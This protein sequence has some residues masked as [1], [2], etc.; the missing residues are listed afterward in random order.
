MYPYLKLLFT[1]Y[2]ARKHP[3][4]TL[5]ESSTL[6]LRAGLTD[7][8]IFF[9]LNHA[10]YI[11]YMELARWDHSCRIG[12]VTLMKKKRWAVAIGGVSIRYRRRI[13]FMRKFTLTTRLLCHDQRWFYFLQETH[14]R[15][16]I[17]SSA[18]VKAGVT[19]RE[20]LVPATDVLKVMGMQDWNPAM[21]DWVDAWIKAEGLR[22]WPTKESASHDRLKQH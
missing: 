1:L 16:R 3:A 7:I 21:P 12:F 19:S 10:R 6:Q 17:C 9:E 13:P 2:K 8:D 15:N 14:S 5:D 11:T 18:L 22:P 20:G 4:I